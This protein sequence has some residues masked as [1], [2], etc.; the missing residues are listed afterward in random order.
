MDLQ[1]NSKSVPAVAAEDLAPGEPAI[2]IGEDG[3]VDVEEY[4]AWD[5]WMGGEIDSKGSVN[6]CVHNRLCEAVFAGT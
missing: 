3:V 2:T 1:Q 6:P 4:M 5:I